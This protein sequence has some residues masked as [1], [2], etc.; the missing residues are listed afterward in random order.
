MPDIRLSVRRRPIAWFIL[1]TLLVTYGLGLPWAFLSPSLEQDLGLREEFLSLM[2]MRFGPTIAG[3][4]VVAAIAGRHGMR[5][6]LR[7]LLR[8]RVSLRYYAA[9]AVFVALPFFVTVLGTVPASQ[10][11]VSAD[12]SAARDWVGLGIGYV[13][14]IAYITLTNGEETGWRF[15]LMPLLLTRFRVWQAVAATGVIWAFWHMPAFFLFGQAAE[16]F[17]LIGIC[18][19]WA[20]LYGW[21]YL[22]SGSLLLP[23]IAHGAANATFYIYEAKFPALNA[24]WEAMGPTGDWIFAAGGSALAA[25]VIFRDCS[26]FQGF[27]QPQDDEKWATRPKDRF[28]DRRS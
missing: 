22:R 24:Y 8:W 21:L 6:W 18:M 27:H 19:A 16:W 17:P 5:I 26:L 28:Q 11:G 20:V 15:V 13:K 1:L 14:E 9:V 3:L 12:L 2:I 10:F 25:V 7:Q 4:L 23:V